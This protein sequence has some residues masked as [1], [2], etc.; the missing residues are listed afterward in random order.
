MRPAK[1]ALR[2]VLAA[3]PGNM[4]LIPGN[5]IVSSENLFPQVVLRTPYIS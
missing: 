2:R 5:Y 3:K 1:I 4:S